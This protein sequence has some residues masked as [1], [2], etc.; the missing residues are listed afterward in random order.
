MS[1]VW[2]LGSL[3]MYV[4]LADLLCYG[5][6]G[7]EDLLRR[8]IYVRNFWEF[9]STRVLSPNIATSRCPGFYRPTT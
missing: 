6:H 4:I 8:Y 2:Y 9:G 7:D 5:R 3:T 1:G